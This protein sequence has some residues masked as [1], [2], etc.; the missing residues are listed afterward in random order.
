[1]NSLFEPEIGV[2]AGT[3]RC[4]ASCK[5]CCF[6]CSPKVKKRLSLEQLKESVDAIA[7]FP[8][9]KHIVWTGG[10]IFTLGTDLFEVMSYAHSKYKFSSRCVTNAYWAKNLTDTEDIIKKLKEYGLSEINIS[11]GDNH[12][13]FGSINKVINLIQISLSH[14]IPV[15]L[16]IEDFKGAKFTKD[17]FL[18]IIKKYSISTEEMKLLTVDTGP[19]LPMKVDSEINYDLDI[20]PEID[21]PCNSILNTVIINPEQKL[22]SC[23]GLTVEYISNMK[24]DYV[25]KNNIVSV[26]ENQFEDFIKIWINVS[27]PAKVLD[28]VQVWDKSIFVPKFVHP[29]QACGFLFNNEKVMHAIERNYPK[30]LGSVLENFKA[31]LE[32]LS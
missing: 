32:L 19:W 11:T 24:N 13:Q 12:Q 16:F 22:L 23:C 18:E 25:N 7:E 30:I 28:Q 6:E 3:F 31:K 10:E 1:M 15:A 29:C 9:I 27:G 20:G 26:F 4:S 5:N 2:I 21:T 14:Q 8:K 17:V